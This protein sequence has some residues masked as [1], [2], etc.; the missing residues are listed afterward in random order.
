MNKALCND[1]MGDCD[2]FYKLT[3]YHILNAGQW[4]ETKML[5]F[6]KQSISKILYAS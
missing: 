5:Q 1:L 3:S 2:K 6:L 4:K